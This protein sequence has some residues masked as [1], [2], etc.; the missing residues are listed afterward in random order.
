MATDPKNAID[1]GPTA[2][3]VGDAFATIEETAAGLAGDGW[4]ASADGLRAAAETLRHA[5]SA[6]LA[7]YS[8]AHDEGAEDARA[9]AEARTA[10]ATK[11]A[12]EAEARLASTPHARPHDVAEDEARRMARLYYEAD[13][14]AAKAEAE[15]ARLRGV[16]EA[17]RDA[18]ATLTAIHRGSAKGRR[19]A[20]ASVRDD[21]LAALDSLS[22]DGGG[23]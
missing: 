8:R 20:L 5:H 21:L 2:N 3:E 22:T 4:R 15:A 1:F 19:A 7:A 16:V 9:D 13:D 12:E 23:K 11:R 18:V 17:V 6:M 14:R 10:A